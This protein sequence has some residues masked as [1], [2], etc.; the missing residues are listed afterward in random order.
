[1]LSLHK[2]QSP[3]FIVITHCVC[4]FAEEVKVMVAANFV[5]NHWKRLVKRSKDTGNTLLISSGATGSYLLKFK[6]APLRS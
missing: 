4:S 6:M 1:M 3:L 2:T 5:L